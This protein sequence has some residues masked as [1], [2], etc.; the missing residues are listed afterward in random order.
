MDLSVNSLDYLK[1]F[2]G[3]VGI[4]LTPCVYPLIPITAGY[5]GSNC[6]GSK[7]KGLI[8]SL[9]YVTGVSVTFSILGL[10]ASLTGTIFGRISSH[11]LANLFVGLIIIIFGL[12]MFGLFYFPSFN[13]LKLTGLKKNSYFAT[14][15][16]GLCSGLAVSPCLTPV[17]GSILLYLTTKKN[18]LYG[19]TLLLSFGYGMGML[20][21]L[22]G[23]FSSALF[24]LPKSGK[25]MLYIK[26]LSASIV[27]A[28]GVYFI[29]AGI[30]RIIL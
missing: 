4:S 23:T 22:V 15:L 17:L 8:S 29:I 16:F 9:V 27:I 1:A 13:I 25:W 5:I 10:L 3:G 21:V 20:L 11:P 14:F 6:S 28:V 26:R 18:L 30:R 2:L 7:L 12:S 24:K 19:I